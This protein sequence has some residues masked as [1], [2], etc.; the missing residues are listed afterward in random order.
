MGL[1]VVRQQANDAEN[2]KA[3]ELSEGSDAR[4]RARALLAR[5]SFGAIRQRVA[6]VRHCS[7]AVSPQ[8]VLNVVCK[9][10]IA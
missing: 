8:A 6:A 4:L 3:A 5:G 2:C 10:F 1:E 9:H 7:V